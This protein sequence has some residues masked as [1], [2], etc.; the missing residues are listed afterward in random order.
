MLLISASVFILQTRFDVCKN[1]KIDRYFMGFSFF[2]DLF[3]LYDMTVFCI[4]IYHKK[5]PSYVPTVV[6][7][8]HW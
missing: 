2:S 1:E 3:M 6:H 5:D 7:P 4:V 8:G